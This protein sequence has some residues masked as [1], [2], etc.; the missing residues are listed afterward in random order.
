M[1]RKC[2]RVYLE[3]SERGLHPIS[4]AIAATALSLGSAGGYDTQG[5]LFTETLSEC[6]KTELEATGLSEIL[7]YTG[8]N[9]RGFLPEIQSDILE[10]LEKPEIF[11]FP[12]TPEGR[13]LSSMMG[14]RLHTGVTA[15]CTALSFTQDGRLLQT[16]PAFSG[17][18]Q[19][20]ILTERGPQLA[21][22]RFGSPVLQIRSASVVKEIPAEK[23]ECY[24]VSW[25]VHSTQSREKYKIVLAL[26]GGIQKKEDLFLFEALAEKLGAEL[27]CSRCLVDRGWLGRE[28]QIG[29]SGDRISAKLLIAFGISGSL[30]FQA[31]L[32]EIGRLCVVDVNPSTALMAM[33]DTPIQGDLY[34]IAE[35]LME[36]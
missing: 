16:R 30:Q 14:A 36:A 20:Q 19:A 22:L 33:A 26:G 7:V 10:Q 1:D 13:I 4:Q 31:G 28:K 27:K 9:F 3:F 24:S 18:R 32:G 5:I 11:L 29:L 15:D 25:L 35:A 8:E 17:T 34:E 2:L 12:S 21:S 23:R 6:K